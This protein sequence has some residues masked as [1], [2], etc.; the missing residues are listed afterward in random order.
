MALNIKTVKISFSRIG[1]TTSNTARRV[2]YLPVATIK[3]MDAKRKQKQELLI[4]ASLGD[5]DSCVISK[6][7]YLGLVIGGSFFAVLCKDNMYHFF[8][9]EGEHITSREII[10]VPV[11][12]G[13]DD[14]IVRNGDIL[15]MYSATGEMLR[16]RQLTQEEKEQLK[17]SDQ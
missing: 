10:G 12:V 17:E 3:Y 14:F 1:I 15:T 9:E 2:F 11:Q 16:W 6:D 13:E 4:G 7:T 5:M 8:N